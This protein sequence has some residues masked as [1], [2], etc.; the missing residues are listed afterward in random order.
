MSSSRS[1]FLAASAKYQAE[2]SSSGLA[3]P[4]DRRVAVVTCMDARID[5]YAALGLKLGEAHVIRNAGGVIT[6]DVIRS[7]CISQQKMGTNEVAVI[8][9]TRCGMENL[10]EA[11]FISELEASTGAEPTWPL[12]SFS[13]LAQDVRDSVAAL[14]ASPFL[15]YDDAITGYIYDVDTGGLEEIAST[16]NKT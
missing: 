16:V 9:H 12:G 14:V 8:H 7:L 6:D 15:A 13:D 3:A 2:F 5:P 10:D 11:V 4:P 1:A